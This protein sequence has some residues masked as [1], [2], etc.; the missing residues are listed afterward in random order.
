MHGR[1]LAATLAALLSLALPSAASAAT[2]TVINGNDGGA[3]SLR[4]AL[5]AS[6]AT[7]RSATRSSSTRA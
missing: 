1:S 3:G 7:P 2:F 4:A 6:N 5:D